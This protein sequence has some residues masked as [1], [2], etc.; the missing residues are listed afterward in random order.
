MITRI[1]RHA[2]V[3]ALIAAVTAGSVTAGAQRPGRGRVMRPP[4]EAGA[5]QPRRQALEKEFRQRSEQIVREKL[6][7]NDEQAARLRTVNANLSAQRNTLV[8]QER[9]VRLDLRDEMGKGS[10]ADQARVSQLLNQARD[11]QT[12]RFALQQEEQQQLS[13][14]MTPV[15]VAQYVGLQAQIRQRIREMQQG[16]PGELPGTVP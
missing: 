4:P 1:L 5:N 6:N 14:F 12:R 15:Q 9:S 16:Q 7:L 3:V 8:Q 10:S 13:A 11:L 2:K